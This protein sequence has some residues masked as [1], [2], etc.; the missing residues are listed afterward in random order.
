MLTASS[1]KHSNHWVSRIQQSSHGS[2]PY[3]NIEQI[4][5]TVGCNLYPELSVLTLT[6]VSV[7]TDNSG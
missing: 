2:Q 5:L 7:R 3:S 4:Y 1:F 6:P